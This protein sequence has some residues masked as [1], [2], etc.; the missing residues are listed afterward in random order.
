MRQAWISWLKA[1]WSLCLYCLCYVSHQL[2]INIVS[3]CL[4]T[5]GRRR[6]EAVYIYWEV[7]DVDKG[8]E[9]QQQTI[10]LEPFRQVIVD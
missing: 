4:G 3:S 5:E 8:F 7:K 10:S 6:F 2:K 9:L 1:P